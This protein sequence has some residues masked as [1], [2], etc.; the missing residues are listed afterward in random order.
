MF[1][2]TVIQGHAPDFLTDWVNQH[3]TPPA[4][5]QGGPLRAA[6]YARRSTSDPTFISI[7]RQISAALDHCRKIGASLDAEHHIYIDRNRSGRTMAGRASLEALLTAARHGRF[8]VV[9]V[10]GLE[11]LT[12]NTADAV[13]IHAEL[14]VLGIAIHV[15]GKGL[16][17]GKEM[18]LRSFQHEKEL[19]AIVERVLDG[20]RRA[21][22]SGN[23]IGSRPKYGYDQLPGRRGLI[24]NSEQASVVRR[25]FESINGGMSCRQ[26][27]RKLKS[28]QVSGPG[29][30][31]WRIYQLYQSRGWG[32][33]QDQVYKGVWTWG[34]GSG[35]P[36]AVDAPDLA[37]VDAELFD[38]VNERLR[39]PVATAWAKGTGVGLLTGIGKC[40][41]GRS[42]IR[43]GTRLIC[44]RE[45]HMDPCTARSEIPLIEAER[46]YYRVLLDEVLEPSRFEDWQLVR[47]ESLNEMQL[48][49]ECERSRIGARLDE[50]MA[51]LDEFDDEVSDNPI[52]SAIVGPLE[53]EFHDLWEKREELASL[54]ALHVDRAEA[55]GLR[56]IIQRMIVKV[57]YRATDPQEIAAVS[58]M[59][60]LVPRLIV[61]RQDGRIVLRFLLGVL[62]PGQ[63]K[64]PPEAG[65]VRWIRRPCPQTPRGVIRRPEAVLLHHREAEAG[66]YVFDDREWAAVAH[67]FEP[68]GRLKGG[69][70]LYAEA[71]IF[72]ARTGM[73][74]N[75]LPERY[76]RRALQM[77]PIRESGIWPRMLALLD[78]MDSPLVRGID[79]N[80]FAGRRSA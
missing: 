60:E 47:A 37:I 36:V 74:T 77:R 20:R 23:M 78:A 17:S 15:V 33:L 42:M 66:R 27:V 65:S 59:H 63:E 75:M 19:D 9:I 12:R 58:R 5:A 2:E 41:C 14:E 51:R 32:L 76:A 30:R 45:L 39:T 38:R 70:R 6:I 71:M 24:I 43:S 46:Q 8:D 16:I 50:I 61:G 29:G 11:R 64:Q 73:P 57:P 48:S 44:H 26:L 54:T 22:E 3:N 72:V 67:L 35:N 55:E 53:A 1:D 13:A 68:M 4:T 80:R 56:A 40:I 34:R 28:E 10:Q 69:H 7:T 18:I 31:P 79:R 25:C 52:L 49:A 21:A 62:S